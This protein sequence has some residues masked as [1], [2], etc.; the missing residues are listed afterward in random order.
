MNG[1]REWETFAPGACT[2]HSAFSAVLRNDGLEGSH[3][4]CFGDELSELRG[5]SGNGDTVEI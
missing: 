2:L 4:E 1:S 3:R 5:N